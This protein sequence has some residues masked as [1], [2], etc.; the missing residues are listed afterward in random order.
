MEVS[1]SFMKTCVILASLDVAGK[2]DVTVTLLNLSAKKQGW[3][4]YF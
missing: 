4:L 3:H 1:E 2:T